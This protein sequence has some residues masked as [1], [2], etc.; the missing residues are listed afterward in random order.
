M[1]QE[2]SSST[3]EGIALVRAIEASRPESARICYDPIARALIPTLSYTL[4]KLVIDSGIYARISQGAMEFITARERYIDDFLKACLSEGLDQVVLLGAGFDTRAYHIAG[5]EKTRV[6]E[7]DHP[8][9]QAVKLKRLKKVIDPIPDHVTFIPVDFN[10]QTLSERLLAST[11]VEQAKTLFIWQGVTMYLTPESVDSTLAFI[12]NHS[13]PG[14]AL[15]FDYF[16]NEFLRDTS[17]PGVKR[18][19][20]LVQAANE[21]FLFGIDAG[22]AEPFLTQR[23]F[24]EVRNATPEDLKRLYFTGPNAGR[25]LNPYAAIVS[26][27]VKKAEDSSAV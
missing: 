12:A 3:A 25:V 23:G 5:I 19:R 8:A 4:S 22:Q 18:L 27:R 6:F 15:I 2:Q 21:E 10:T 11:Y 9:T 16:S 24:C 1:K 26:A 20:R 7:I 17:R 14:S 13:G